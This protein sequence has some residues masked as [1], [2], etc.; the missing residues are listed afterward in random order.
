MSTS[1]WGA[2]GEATHMGNHQ[3]N[4]DSPRAAISL[5]KWTKPRGGRVCDLDGCWTHRHRTHHP[6]LLD[7]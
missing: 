6:K 5:P 1:T 3:A 2:S 4:L 7:H